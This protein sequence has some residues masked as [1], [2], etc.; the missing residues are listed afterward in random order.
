MYIKLFPHGKGTGGG[1]INYLLRLDYPGRQESPP[2]VMRGDPSLTRALIDSQERQ[3][4]FSAGVLS[5]GPEDTVTPEQ[6]RRLM[7]DFEAT[8]FAGLEA[9]QYSIL[10]VRH[11]H[12][13]H[14]ELHFV[15]PRM[16]LNTGKA[17]NAFP[18]GWQ[19]D[20]DVLR[21]LYNWQEGWTRP[22]DPQRARVRTPEH[23]DVHRARLKRWGREQKEKENLEDIRAT[24]TEYLV[25]RI[26]LGSVTTREECITAL[27]ELGLFVP[28]Q[29]KDYITVEEQETGQRVR[30]KGGIYRAD[31]RL[32]P[33]DTATLGNGESRNRGSSM[34]DLATLAGKLERVCQRRADYHRK[35]YS[36]PEHGH[37]PTREQRLARDGEALQPVELDHAQGVDS[38]LPISSSLAGGSARRK[39]GLYHAL[40]P[41]HEQCTTGNSEFGTRE[42]PIARNYHSH[43]EQDMGLA[44][45]QRQERAFHCVAP[46]LESRFQLDD[47][48][49]TGHQIGVSHDRITEHPQRNTGPLG[50]RNPDDITAARTT[51]NSTQNRAAT[52]GTLAFSADD[53]LAALGRVVQA[54]GAI[55]ISL[56]HSLNTQVNHTPRQTET[57]RKRWR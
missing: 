6:E 16:E 28:R 2:Q 21:D 55:I 26:S 12:A 11:S 9:D 22:D 24:L 19:K 33:E 29:G 18:P 42:S 5:W 51:N 40:G 48:Q 7:D 31:W 36:L 13:G 8:A 10:W 45:A 30:L 38:A 1:A 43:A 34:P 14:H 49:A 23:T 53:A 52:N 46:R 35:R 41:K 25:E 39:L 50:N 32:E 15:T 4:K 17:L 47:R 37:E 57:S 44:A 3:W 27:K 54:V 20:F 56:E